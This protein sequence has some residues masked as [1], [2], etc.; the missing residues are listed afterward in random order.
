MTIY[1]FAAATVAI[2][3]GVMAFVLALKVVRRNALLTEILETNAEL[4]EVK[5]R[6]VVEMAFLV[7]A[8]EP[9]LEKTDWMTGRWGGQYNV[10]VRMEERR[11]KIIDDVRRFV[12]GTYPVEALIAED[13]TT[14]IPKMNLVPGAHL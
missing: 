1:F 13:P 11:N 6:V 2:I 10:L 12:M 3:F 5:S 8:V 14:L 4:I 7:E 9:L